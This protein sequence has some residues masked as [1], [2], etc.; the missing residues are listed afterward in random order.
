MPGDDP[1][2]NTIATNA[3]CVAALK[4]CSLPETFPV[5][6]CWLISTLDQQ[7]DLAILG[8]IFRELQPE[9][10]TEMSE[11]ISYALMAVIEAHNEKECCSE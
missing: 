11:E 10:L 4:F 9:F 7:S 6:Q 2:V 3:M 8:Q 1:Y 5:F